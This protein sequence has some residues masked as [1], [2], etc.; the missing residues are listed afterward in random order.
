[1]FDNQEKADILKYYELPFD[2][3]DKETFIKKRKQLRAK[4][5]PD[6]F[7]KYDDD[8][9]KEMATDRFQSIE[10]L[11]EKLAAA[12][13]GKPAAAKNNGTQPDYRHSSAVFAA[14]KLKIEIIADDKD[15]KYT[16]FG[17]RYRWL[18]LGDEFKIPGTDAVIV[19]DEDHRGTSI[20]F[21]ET[22]RIYLTFGEE[23]KITEIVD[24]FFPRI[25]NGAQSLLIGGDKI[26]VNRA[27]ILQALQQ[28]TF[29]RLS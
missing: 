3:L 4:Y 24:W 1:M 17:R 22:I 10:K 12:F 23:Q 14:K 28:R 27:A 29:L 13:A 5:H 25:E 11:S 6:N 21:R 20:G 18:L 9:V 2:K 15:L 16:L 8:T 26:E 7:A 19:T